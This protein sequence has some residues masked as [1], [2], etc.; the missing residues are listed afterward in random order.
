M[1]SVTLV[2]LNSVE[3][4]AD[5][6]QSNKAA[7]MMFTSVAVMVADGHSGHEVTTSSTAWC[8]WS[9]RKARTV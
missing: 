8:G 7:P 5:A 4:Q 3:I 1:H 6:G 2:Y 9:L